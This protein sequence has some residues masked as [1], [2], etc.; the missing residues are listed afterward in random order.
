MIIVAWPT[1]Y[2]ATLLILGKLANGLFNSAGSQG[3]ITWL[4]LM[5][6]TAAI[7]GGLIVSYLVYERW[8]SMAWFL[9]LAGVS[10]ALVVVIP[11]LGRV[12]PG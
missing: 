5:S 12:L 4:G 2:L 6:V 7:P 11:L 1:V 10:A 8:Q 3:Y 9:A